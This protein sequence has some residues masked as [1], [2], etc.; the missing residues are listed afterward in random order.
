MRI[1]SRI[2]VLIVFCCGILCA[3]PAESKVCFAGDSDC[4]GI[5]TFGGYTDPSENLRDQCTKA[6]YDTPRSECTV[7]KGMQVTDYCPYDSNFVKCCSLDY[8]YDSCVY[9]MVQAGKCGNKYKCVCDSSKYKY[10]A[11][12]CRS[13][14]A[15]SNASGASCAQVE[16]NASAHTTSTKIFFTDCSCNEA[17][18]PYKP[19]DCKDGTAPTGDV[20]YSINMNGARETRYSACLCNRDIY[21]HPTSYCDNPSSDRWGG[22]D[23]RKCIQGGVTYFAN[24]LTCGSSYPVTTKE[25]IS[26]VACRYLADVKRTEEVID[27]SRIVTIGGTQYYKPYASATCGYAECPYGPRYKALNCKFGYEVKN[28]VCSLM[29]CKQIIRLFTKSNHT[30]ALIDDV[31]PGSTQGTVLVASGNTTVSG[32]RNC[33]FGK[34]LNCGSGLRYISARK[35][36]QSSMVTGEMADAMKQACTTESNL[37]FTGSSFP[38]NSAGSEGNMTFEDINLNI[39][40]PTVYRNI[41]F[42]SGTLNVGSPT[43]KKQLTL[44]GGDGWMKGTAG[45]ITFENILDTQDFNFDV[46]IINFN[47]SSKNSIIRNPKSFSARQINQNVAMLYFYG[48][49]YHVQEII[50]AKSKKGSGSLNTNGDSKHFSARLQ[51]N[52][53]WFLYKNDSTKYTDDYKIQANSCS[54]F[55]VENGSSIIQVNRTR[56]N[57]SVKSCRYGSKQGRYLGNI[58]DSLAKGSGT[59]WC[60]LEYDRCG[61][62]HDCKGSCSSS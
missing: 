35:F 38:Y 50:V 26:G 55:R 24:C 29:T 18:Y 3:T 54:A 12:S 51:N 52:G 10:T 27:S 37:T 49:E 19:E 21:Q 32:V 2:N 23:S 14:F 45:T 33:S 48:G 13:N 44:R 30:Y 20:C 42:Q 39:S 56:T 53:K 15:N 22:D 60:S 34:G 7:G 1:L 16:Y 6:G 41:T 25:N 57:G 43:F 4:G 31:T 46:G 47:G 59:G 28:G 58:S 62:D 40:S 11:E 9:P 17:L 36:A 5:E 8:Q 61:E